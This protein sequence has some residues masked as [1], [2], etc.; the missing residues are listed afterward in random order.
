MSIC[1]YYNISPSFSFLIVSS[2]IAHLNYFFFLSF[3]LFFFPFFFCNSLDILPS[4]FSFLLLIPYIFSFTSRFQF[5]YPIFFLSSYSPQMPPIATTI[6]PHPKS[7]NN[8]TLL[9]LMKETTGTSVA[10]FL[11]TDIR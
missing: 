4:L 7:L 9:N 1:Q 11:C 10:K 3:F 8:I 5:F 6:L 2:L